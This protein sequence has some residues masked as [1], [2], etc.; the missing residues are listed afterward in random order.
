VNARTPPPSGTLDLCYEGDPDLL[1]AEEATRRIRAH[2]PVIEDAQEVP[3][4]DALARVLAVDV[5]SPLDV[6]GHTNSAVDGYA[7]D[8]AD[9]PAAGERVLD[10]VGRAF[11]GAPFT[12]PV[13]PGECVRIMTGAVM[14]AGTDTVIMQEHVRVEAGRVVLGAGHRAGQN[15]REA[16]EDLRA[17]QVMLIRGTR[18]MPAAL[19]M[20]ASVGIPSVSVIRPLRVGFFSTGDELRSLGEA[21]QPGQ[22]YDSNRYTL[23]GMLARLGVQVRDL[24]VVRDDPDRLRAALDDACSDCDVVISSGGVSTGDADHVQ[25]ILAERG[26]VG[27]WRI[28]VRPGR[29]LAFGRLGER[30]FF[31]LPGNPVAVMITFYQFVQPALLA[32][33]GVAAVAPPLVEAECPHPLRKKPGRVEYFRA[34]LARDDDGVLRVRATGKTGS[35]LLHTMNDANCLIVLPAD[36]DSLD[37]GC[38]VP[39]QPFFGL[40]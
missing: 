31:G 34:V 28:A 16:G 40:V 20:L 29:P 12:D 14:P 7:L 39:V 26:Q 19:G 10:V 35:G 11:A 32:M 38:T 9:L 5:V 8:G 33:M 27:F 4:G 25:P 22:V 21:L 24:G 2:V 6:P 15:V 36:S 18:L 3:L 17:G 30:V 1:P 23:H 37:A 13:G